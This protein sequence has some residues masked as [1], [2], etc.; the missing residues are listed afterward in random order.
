MIKK[1]YDDFC[2]WEN[3]NRE[4]LKTIWNSC[5]MSTQEF[6]DYDFLS[7]TL[8]VYIETLA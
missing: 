2:V 3:L 1:F 7:F 8:E 6:F 5:D 4:D